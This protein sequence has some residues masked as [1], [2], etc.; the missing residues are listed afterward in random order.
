MHSP[1]RLARYEFGGDSPAAV[2]TGQ[3]GSYR[4][5]IVLTDGAG[6]QYLVLWPKPARLVEALPAERRDGAGR[7]GIGVDLGNGS[8]FAWLGQKFDGGGYFDTAQVEELPS[9][10]RPL[11]TCGVSKAVLVGPPEP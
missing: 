6:V 4:D 2:V 7:L 10:D 9:V 11:H 8:P 5:C 1:L 3:L